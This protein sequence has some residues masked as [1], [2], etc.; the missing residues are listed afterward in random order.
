MQTPSIVTH[1]RDNIHASQ[2]ILSFTQ[3]KFRPRQFNR[4]KIAPMGGGGFTV[5]FV[6][7]LGPW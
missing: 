1:S 7:K 5:C 6:F 2:N 3:I 4:I